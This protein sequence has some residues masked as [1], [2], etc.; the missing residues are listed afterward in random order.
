MN[1]IHAP[2]TTDPSSTDLA[3]ASDVTAF[4]VNIFA[5]IH[6]A[7]RQGL[8]NLLCQ[9][10]TTDFEQSSEVSRLGDSLESL[11]SFCEEH[12]GHEENVVRPACGNRLVPEAFDRGH[13]QHLRFIAEIRGLFRAVQASSKKHRPTLAHALYLHF[14]VFMADCL[15]HMAEE[16]RV[17][18]PLM[19]KALGDKEVLAIRERIL[20]SLS[21]A[22]LAKDARRMLAAGN[23]TEQRALVLGILA[24]APRPAAI[25]LVRSTESDLDAAS[26]ARLMSL[27][28]SNPA[29]A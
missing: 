1:A 21:P 8:A 20:G 24:K 23:A 16:E 6:K 26:F 5:G 19:L 12:L 22:A 28:E 3:A 25:E 14:S 11:L 29:A 7:I 17:L 9:L 13:P 18:L 27:I 15:E 10:G 4:E 2:S